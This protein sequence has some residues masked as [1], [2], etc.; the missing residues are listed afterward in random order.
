MVAEATKEMKKIK[1]IILRIT[2][3]PHQQ[4]M[5]DERDFYQYL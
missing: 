5:N 1:Q 4:L 2:T 3:Q